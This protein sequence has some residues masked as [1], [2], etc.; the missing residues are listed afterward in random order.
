M[1]HCL[2]LKIY[3]QHTPYAQI[4]TQVYIKQ[5]IKLYDD[6]FKENP[7]TRNERWWYAHALNE[8]WVNHSVCCRLECTFT[9]GKNIYKN[10]MNETDICIIY[11]C[12]E[13]IHERFY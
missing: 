2:P 12:I 5:H 11:V 7:R 6:V 3:I 13:N 10:D 4:H 1:S 9:N 8:N